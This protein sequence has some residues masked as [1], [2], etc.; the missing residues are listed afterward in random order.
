MAAALFSHKPSS[1]PPR[2]T[3]CLP[4]PHCLRP[5]NCRVSSCD[6]HTGSSW[7]AHGP[8]AQHGAG[9]RSSHPWSFGRCPAGCHRRKVGSLL[10]SRR[11]ERRAP[12]NPHS[13]CVLLT[14][15][16]QAPN[17]PVFHKACKFCLW[18]LLRNRNQLSLRD[19]T[20]Q[21][22]SSQA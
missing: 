13:C 17:T 21:S 1:S 20:C 5:S 3:I 10:T 6:Q 2:R 11:R 8:W 7:R 9:T 4:W 14:R 15:L 19:L 12:T 18:Q 16:F 22:A